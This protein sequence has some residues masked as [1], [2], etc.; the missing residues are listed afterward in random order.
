MS[1]KNV[2]SREHSAWSDLGIYTLGITGGIGSGKSYVA[3]ILATRGIPV[4]DTDSR[5]KLLY[6]TDAGLRD[7][8]IA[9]CGPGIYSSGRLDRKT[10]STLIFSDRALLD[11]VNSLVHP[12]V[13]RDFCRWREALSKSGVR[14]CA[15]ESA[16]LLGAGLESYVDDVLVVLADDALRLQRA[17]LRDGAS[18][19]AVRARMRHQ[20]TQEELVRRGDFLIY[21]DGAH[22]LEAQLE[23]LLAQIPS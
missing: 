19:E 14:A 1:L 5:A 4:Y 22:P 21:N 6:D 3:Q 20:M 2:S 16:L 13:R 23:S 18:E 17:V 8:M 12:A 15:L 11:R 9:L 7:S 10:L